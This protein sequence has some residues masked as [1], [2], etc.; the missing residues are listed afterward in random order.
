MQ[1]LKKALQESWRQLK[2]KPVAELT[3]ARFE[4]LMAYGKFKEVEAK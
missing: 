2:D 3:S 4:K 1:A